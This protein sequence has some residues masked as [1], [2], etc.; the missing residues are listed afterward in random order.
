MKPALLVAVMVVVT[1]C[2]PQQQLRSIDD[3]NFLVGT[4]QGIGEHRHDDGHVNRFLQTNE[5]FFDNNGKVLVSKQVAALVDNPDR[6]IYQAVISYYFDASADAFFQKVER[7]DGRVLIEP[8]EVAG[9][10]IAW[11]NQVFDE[12]FVANV[13]GNDMTVTAAPLGSD[14]QV[15]RAEFKR[16]E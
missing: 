10:S 1:A 14:E 7:W 4:W 3:L 9:N 6:V 5:T 13:R 15:F 12:R 2:A 16:L 8:L 11:V